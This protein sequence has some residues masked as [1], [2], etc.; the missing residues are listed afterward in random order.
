MCLYLWL[1]ILLVVGDVLVDTE[2]PVVTV[3]LRCI[4]QYFGDTYKGK[5]YMYIL[6]GECACCERISY[7]S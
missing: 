4:V 3:D 1:I 2:M 5:V 7:V 6:R